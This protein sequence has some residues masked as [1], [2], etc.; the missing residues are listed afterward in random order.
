MRTPTSHEEQYRWHADALAGRRPQ[1]T[2]EPRCGFFKRRFVKDGPF[3]PA[4]IWMV[5]PIDPCTGELI[6][7]EELL[8]EVAG[9]PADAVAQWTHIAGR[10]IPES[11]YHY[12][13]AVSAWA[14][15]HAPNHPLADAQ[16]R[17]DF[18]RAPI[19]F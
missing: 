12:M 17:I 13:M 9:K 10:P 2:H 16:M 14:A 11:E 19:P 5:Q 8:C 3:V 4:R 6:G 7:D 15:R 18:M 1:V